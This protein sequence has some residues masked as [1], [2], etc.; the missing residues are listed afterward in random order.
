MHNTPSSDRSSQRARRSPPLRDRVSAHFLPIGFGT[1]LVMVAVV[2]LFMNEGRAV[3]TAESLDE[4]NSVVKALSS[5]DVVAHENQAKLVHVTTGLFTNEPLIDKEFGISI[6]ACKLNRVV[7]MYQWVEHSHISETKTGNEVREETSYTYDETWS[8]ELIPSSSFNSP[9]T[10]ENP[11]TME[12]ESKSFVSNLIHVG[13]FQL[14]PGLVNKISDFRRFPLTLSPPDDKLRLISDMYYKGR[15]SK[16][17]AIG[18]IRIYFEV[19]GRSGKQANG[20]EV[21]D[22]VSIIAKQLD[23]K[24]LPYQTDAGAEIELL[25]EGEHSVSSMLGREQVSNIFLTWVVR[26]GGWL[27]MFIGFGCMT[28]ILNTLVLR[29]PLI[30]EAVGLSTAVMTAALAVSLSLVV[31]AMGWIRYR[32]LLG[33]FIIVFSLV[34]FLFAKLRGSTGLRSY[35]NANMYRNYFD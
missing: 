30:R 34:P 9:F 5:A 25:Y 28:S 29:L 35:Q 20:E 16:H 27:L 19:A 32:P 14:A 1:I 2:M 17:P 18:D 22:L 21:H 6:H 31:I 4:A 11:E 12:Y 8:K 3:R 10:H 15:D 7:E 13:S 33:L 26:F 24:F 23:D